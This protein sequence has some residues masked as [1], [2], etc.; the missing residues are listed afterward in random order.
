MA[1]WGNMQFPDALFAD[2][3]QKA[4]YNACGFL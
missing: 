3:V 1:S 4:I 2:T